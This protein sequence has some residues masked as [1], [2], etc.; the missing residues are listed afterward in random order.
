MIKIRHIS[1]LLI[2]IILLLLVISC[3]FQGNTDL[4]E[5][6]QA[7]LRPVREAES[8]DGDIKINSLLNAFGIFAEEKDAIAY[9]RS[10]LTD[11]SI[12]SVEGYRTYD[13]DDFYDLLKQLGAFKLKEIIEVHLKNFNTAPDAALA[14]IS[15]VMKSEAKQDLQNRLSSYKDAYPLHLKGLFSRYVLND[16]YLY[17][18]GDDYAVKYAELEDEAINIVVGVDVYAGLSASELRVIDYIRSVVTDVKVGPL[19][20]KT[21]SNSEFYD[22]LNKMR[23]AKVKRMVRIYLK[24]KRAQKDAE[25]EIRTIIANLQGD[26]AKRRLESTIDNLNNSYSVH[27][28]MLFDKSTPD[29]VYDIVTIDDYASRFIRVYHEAR[30]I[31]EFENLCNNEILDAELKAVNDMRN[32]VI[33]SGIGRAEG[34]SMYDDYTFDFLCGSLSSEVLKKVIKLHLEIMNRQEE[35]LGVIKNLQEGYEKQNLQDEFSRYKNAYALHLKML[36]DRSPS[37]AIYDKIV[38]GNYASSFIKLKEAALTE[39]KKSVS[40]IVF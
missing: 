11:L 27:L 29:E 38:K 16:V 2:V 33:N 9:I 34:Y 32:I 14:A 17:I 30:R 8:D 6:L 10:I 1:L 40:Q 18:I 31:L 37:N 35:V 12:G 23:A 15:N 3:E 5:T 4:T 28:K 19:C 26:R 22:L 36:F 24:D 21:Y 13:D 7:S 20:H 39:I 25:A